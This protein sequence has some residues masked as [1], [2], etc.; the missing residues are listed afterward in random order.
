MPGVSP[1]RASEEKGRVVANQRFVDD[2]TLNA[3]LLDVMFECPSSGENC[4]GVDNE[5]YILCVDLTCSTRTG[6][7]LM[8]YSEELFRSIQLEEKLTWWPSRKVV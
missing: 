6:T 4:S 3:E 1:K 5:S 8:Q 7:Y 2:S